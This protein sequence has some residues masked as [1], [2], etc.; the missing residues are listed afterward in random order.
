[1]SCCVNV[2][3]Y[4]DIPINKSAILR[5]AHC[6][7]PNKQVE[8]LVSKC[9]EEISLVYKVCY[10]EFAINHHENS[11]DLCFYKTE[12]RALKKLLENCDSIVLFAATIGFDVDRMI[13]K[14]TRLDPTKALIFQA[15]GTE[16]VESLCDAFEL[17]IQKE[18]GYKLTPRFSPGYADLSLEMQ[19]DVFKALDC[20]KNIGIT[21]NDSLLMTPTK[22][23]TAI[24]GVHRR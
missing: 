2:K 5:Y 9:L 1:M 13:V 19:S 8:N 14:N 6:F 20:F 21:L 22:S 15:I 4:T 11:L 17:D 23:V 12:S 16:R 10:R 7:E 3:T 24:L 18:F